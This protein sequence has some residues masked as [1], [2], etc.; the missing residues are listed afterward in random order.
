MGRAAFPGS[1]DPPTVAHLAV[2]RAALAVPGVDEV[3]FALSEAA[4]GKGLGAV[5]VADRATVLEA[6]A[7]GV[8]G[9]AV[10]RTP[11]RLV[12]EV[13]EA[14]GA[15]TVVLGADKWAQVR[16]PA[17]Y[18][19]SEAERDAALARLPRVL[20]APRTGEL[21]GPE[22]ARGPEVVLLTLDPA[23][24]DVSATR[25]RGGEHHLMLPEAAASD[26]WT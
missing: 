2:A 12:V 23:H 14:L 10:A 4:L 15:D 1:F 6:V 9:L 19:G 20:L 21:A 7:A 26:L 16:D 13:A 5:S 25:A 17:W 8:P 11:A 24:G 3:C 18:G 22:V